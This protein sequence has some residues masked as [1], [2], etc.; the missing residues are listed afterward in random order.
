MKVKL[1]G[2]VYSKISKI[3]EKIRNLEKQT[4]KE[5][6][7][8]NQG[9]NAVCNINLNKV[10]PLIDFNSREIQ[11]YA[12]MKGRPNLKQAI[13]KE[14]FASKSTENNILISNGGMNGL[15]IVF[16][17]IDVDKIY[18]PLYFWGSYLNIAKIRNVN[19]GFYTDFA[20]IENNINKYKNSAVIICDP[21]NPLGDKF[22]DNRL[23]K[24]IKTLNNND[25]VIIIDSP[26]RKV[27]HNNDNYFETIALLNNVIIVESFSKSI[28]LSGQRIG[29]VHSNNEALNN[30]LAVKLMYSSNGVNAF[31][32]ILVEKLLTTNEGKNAIKEFKEKTV[33]DINNNILL[34]KN[35]GLL[36]KE[37]YKNSEP[38]G[39]FAVVNKSEEELLK[40]NIAS[41]SLSFFTKNNKEFASNYSRI[42]VSVPSKKFESFFEKI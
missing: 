14:Y 15:D 41:V 30:E 9:V 28:G 25:V 27:F 26:Y 32:Q 3:G 38:E 23:I 2:A 42:C 21:N 18:L 13:N 12:P 20:E 37:F 11:V 1:S 34:L 17:S 10:I 19:T 29:F 5:Y 22:D 39:I 31:S 6:L 16:Q 35:K 24:L 7:Y 40:H 8:L 4:G 36:A 33:N